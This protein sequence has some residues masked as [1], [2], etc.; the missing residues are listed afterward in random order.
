MPETLPHRSRSGT[1]ADTDAASIDP[2]GYGPRGAEPDPPEVDT[3][4]LLGLLSNDYARAI[5]AEISDEALPA[6]EIARRLDISRATV[7]RRLD[8]LEEAGVLKSTMSCEPNGNHRQQ[9]RVIVDR[10]A[11]SLESDGISVDDVDRSAAR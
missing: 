7:Y 10:L 5:M 3:E 8:W 11:L 2:R 4:E 9:F 1:D 6:R